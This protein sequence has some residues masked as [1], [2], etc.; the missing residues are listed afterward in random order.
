[1]NSSWAISLLVRPSAASRATRNS[2]DV[3][4]VATV[5]RVRDEAGRRQLPVLP[6]LGRPKRERRNGGPGPGLGA[7]ARGI[8][9]ER[10]ACAARHPGRQGR[11]RAQRARASPGAC[12]SL[13]LAA[14]GHARPRGQRPGRAGATPTA[15]PVP[16]R[17]ASSSSSLASRTASAFSPMA[18][19]DTAALERYGV[20]AGL[21]SPQAETRSPTADRSSIAPR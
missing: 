6:S 1:M 15:R 14:R 2:L 11:G 9:S 4:G 17:R 21:A 19:S 13:R 8:G 7:A 10:L 3:S 16:Q 20:I 12:W 18:A 5:D